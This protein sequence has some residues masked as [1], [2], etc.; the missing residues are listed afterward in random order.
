[1]AQRR[2]FTEGIALDDSNEEY[3]LDDLDD[4]G[5]QNYNNGPR[6]NAVQEELDEEDE[7]I[8]ESNNDDAVDGNFKG[9]Y[10]NDDPNNKFTDPETGAHFE[11]FDFCKR[12]VKLQKLRMQIDIQ[13]GIV[14]SD[15]NSSKEGNDKKGINFGEQPVQLQASIQNGYNQQ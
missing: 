11:Y 15:Q 12:L 10:I 9:I 3:D 5:Q 13:L 8:D 7:D 1:M 14:S 2:A 6:D 4:N